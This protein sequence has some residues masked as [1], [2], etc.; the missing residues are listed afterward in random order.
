MIAEITIRPRITIRD[1]AA[2]DRAARVIEKA[3]QNCLISKS[4]K[5]AVRL[6]AEISI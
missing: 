3:E 1:A 6:E 5:T 2:R 4:M